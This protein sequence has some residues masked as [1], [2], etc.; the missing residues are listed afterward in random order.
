MTL[1]KRYTTYIVGNPR[2]AFGLGLLSSLIVILI[3]FAMYRQ[4]V[5]EFFINDLHLEQEA[6]AS[7]NNDEVDEVFSDIEG[8]LK[9]ARTVLSGQESPYSAESAE[10]LQKI[11][12]NRNYSRIVFES[13]KPAENSSLSQAT[14][15]KIRE[16]SQFAVQH[17]AGQY[18][19]VA[20][21][22]AGRD[23]R[24]TN[25]LSAEITPI[26]LHERFPSK[27]DHTSFSTFVL[28]GEGGFVV[29][30]S[31]VEAM[32][33]GGS[34]ISHLN[35]LSFAKGYS[36]AVIVQD[37]KARHT[38]YATYVQSNEVKHIYYMPVGFEDWMMVIEVPDSYLQQ[39]IIYSVI[40]ALVF[41]GGVIFVIFLMFGIFWLYQRAL[42]TKSQLDERCF[43]VLAEHSRDVVFEWD[44]ASDRM[45][46]VSN[47]ER[48]FAGD[49][50]VWSS[51]SKIV[52]NGLVHPDDVATFASGIELIR[53][54]GLV[55]EFFFRAL[56]KNG[57]WIWCSFMGTIVSDFNNEPYRIIGTISNID[58][59][60]RERERLEAEAQ[61]DLMT[62]LFNKVSAVRLIENY[63]ETN[64]D[65][66]GLSAMLLIDL[67]DLKV[68]NDT[69][70]HPAG[71]KVLVDIA[72][73][74]VEHFR[75]SDVIGRMGGDEF[76]VFIKDVADEDMVTQRVKSLE[77]KLRMS[78]LFNDVHYQSSVS[79][80]AVCT[81]HD[82]AFDDLYHRVDV[83]L[84]ASKRLNKVGEG[85]VCEDGDR[86]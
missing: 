33:D 77:K 74:L 32:K 37:I 53:T 41:L 19:I 85:M 9:S 78:Y 52:E 6:V 59:L 83:A 22:V 80:G 27:P 51:P 23:G 16:G 38:G 56:S 49:P 17:K 82:V 20:I 40:S 63:L 14:V 57:N 25:I 69:C 48:Q 76:I 15:E 42:V 12:D 26:F 65:H 66:L 4:V 21:P 2:S 18:L 24:P 39:K 11:A 71:D 34:Y 79:I 70:G 5:T 28:D 75:D 64:R 81:T 44:I 73:G 84:Y 67:D 55:E 46:T 35:H 30:P 7:A 13:I 72:S 29:A 62:G 61:R 31:E 10:L 8:T 1:V 47:A 50:D 60:V 58:N 54:N 68:L 43:R 36:R 45:L 3:F 86:T